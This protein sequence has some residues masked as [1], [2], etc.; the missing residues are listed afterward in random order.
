M[1]VFWLFV[2]GIIWIS[3]LIDVLEEY[4]IHYIETILGDKICIVMDD[5]VPC[6]RA[7][8]IECHRYHNEI[9]VWKIQWSVQLP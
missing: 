9:H 2:E 7:C 8:T 5:K 3:S 1:L 6:H 4:L